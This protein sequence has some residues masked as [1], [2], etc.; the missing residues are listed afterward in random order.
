MTPSRIRLD[1]H[2]AALG[3]APSRS[4]ARDMV[5]RGCVRVDGELAAKH[6]MMVNSDCALVIDDPAQGYVSRSALKLVAGLD[7]C[8]LDL[9]NARA[10]DL[11]ASTGGFTQVLLERGAAH[12]V[13]VD[14]GH[15]QLDASIRTDKRV[16]VFE[17][18]NARELSLDH[19]G[20]AP[21]CVV[22]DLSFISLTLGAEPALRLAASGAHCVLLVKP[23]FEVGRDGIGKGGL[24]T[25]TA[26]VERTNE[27][28]RGWLEG[29][30]GWSVTH[31][32][33]SPIKGGDG[34]T[35]FLMCGAKA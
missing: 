35:E 14:V 32:A 11:G 2:L 21:D 19:L 27:R 7:L 13:A 33:P 23:Q 24:V 16:T 28:L 20:Q 29:L 8:G 5:Q 18:L 17:G 30:D 10:V 1:Q 4:R 22:S 26:L 3:H 25:D 31:F 15:D 34:N 6:G 12:V 9:T